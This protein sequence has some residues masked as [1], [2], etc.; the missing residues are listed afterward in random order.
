MRL[1]HSNINY[2]E[3]ADIHEFE[4]PSAGIPKLFWAKK[5]F[6]KMSWYLRLSQ[7]NYLENPICNIHGWRILNLLISV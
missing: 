6:S 5:P 4:V 2:K 3:D 7:S 1:E